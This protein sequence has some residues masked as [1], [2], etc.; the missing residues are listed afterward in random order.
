MLCRNKTILLVSILVAVGS[1]LI[2]VCMVKDFSARE[3]K[4]KE[5]RQQQ[6]TSNPERQPNVSEHNDKGVCAFH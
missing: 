3:R 1:I 6:A 2:F 4:Y 5:E